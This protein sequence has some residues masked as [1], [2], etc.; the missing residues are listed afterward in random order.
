MSNYKLFLTINIISDIVIIALISFFHSLLD[1]HHNLTTIQALSSYTLGSILLISLLYSF[2]L[3]TVEKPLSFTNDGLKILL[4]CLLTYTAMPVFFRFNDLNFSLLAV[5]ITG[6]ISPF[7]ILI[8][9][10]LIRNIVLIKLNDSKI[11]LV[12]DDKS[13]KIM[14]KY[15]KKTTNNEII[16]INVNENESY[17]W[18]EIYSLKKKHKNIKL[19][20]NNDL[21]FKN[22]DTQF[23]IDLKLQGVYVEYFY[24]YKHNIDKRI[25][26]ETI[27]NDWFISDYVFT[28]STFDIRTKRIL[29]I[30][31]SACGLILLIPL[32]FI[33]WILNFNFNSGKLFYYQKRVGHHGNI[34]NII[35]FR[36]MSS[37]AEKSGILW[38]K[39]NDNRV[40]SFGK[41]LRKT[42]IDELPQLWNIFNG[43]MSLVGPRPERPEWVEKIEKTIPYYNLRH[44]VKPGLTGW[45]Q[46]NLFYVDSIER[47]KLKLEYDLFYL[48][49]LNFALDLKIIFKTFQNVI[50]AKGR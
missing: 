29:D 16:L 3:Y 24:K 49:R 47:T 8:T 21:N 17:P 9:K 5:S 13:L 50:F 11:V 42:H 41:W 12:S 37:D 33:I 32:T 39:D 35:K 4:A 45:A 20:F 7:Y 2:D 36:S 31:I 19:C 6:F 27:K 26:L 48:S 18:D 40:T 30:V 34:F 28:N 15:F 44:L 14:I 22:V 46:I 1:H 43:E 23:I 10:W 38:A 25:H